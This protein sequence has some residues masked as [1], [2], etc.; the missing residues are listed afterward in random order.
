MQGI[1]GDSYYFILNKSV[2]YMVFSNIVLFYH[3]YSIVRSL[4]N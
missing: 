1:K 2:K 4:L 3:S